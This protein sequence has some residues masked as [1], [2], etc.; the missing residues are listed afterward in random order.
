MF[1]KCDQFSKRCRRELFHEDGA[2]RMIAIERLVRRQP[3]RRP[4]GQ[5]LLQGFAEGQRLCLSKHISQQQIMV[6]T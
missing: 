4:L 5:Y 6:S 3:F 2:A 1:V